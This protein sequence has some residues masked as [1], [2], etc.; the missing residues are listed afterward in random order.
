[1]SHS[2]HFS[3]V[4]QPIRNDRVRE[5]PSAAFAPA[6]ERI[7]VAD[8]LR[9][10][11]LMGLFIV[12]MV[13]YFELYWYQPEPGW[14]HNTVFFLFGGKAYGV[15]ALLFG[16]SFY[17]ILD[18]HARRGRDF[19]L[20]FCWRLML[21]WFF[22]YVHSLLYA[23]DILQLL[24]ICGFLLVIC[25]RLGN[26]ALLSIALFFLIQG[27]QILVIAWYTVVG[28]DYQAPLFIPH[29]VRNFDVF[30]TGN[31]SDLLRYNLLAGQVGKWLFFFE[32]GRLWQLIGLMFLGAYTGR[33]GLFETPLPRV[34]TLFKGV[35]VAGAA[36]FFISWCTAFISGLFTEGMA[37]WAAEQLLS[38][39]ANLCVIVGGVSLF[40]AAYQSTLLRPT[41]EKL[42]PAGRLTLSF[43]LLQSV[44]F[45][46][47]F[48]GF[49][50]G[51]FAF[52][53][54]AWSLVL[55]IVCC[56]LQIILAAVWLKHFRYGPM[57]WVW[58]RLTFLGAKN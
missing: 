55:A 20:R 50:L 22:G 58:R 44:V 19:R 38:Y 10:F 39:C 53:G 49:G 7:V 48:Y 43:Y 13:E 21:L 37:R 14:I 33:I 54:Q 45:V 52:L 1:M 8:A 51:G 12:H 11:A 25:Q 36:Y 35:I 2:G 46:P 41:I 18:N 24:A 5:R 29:M 17:I 26:N 40:L 28:V 16:L 9:G 23:G 32:T 4:T 47:V 56:L 30:A 15:F 27:P 3:A 42:A 31:I 6:R 34:A 57:E